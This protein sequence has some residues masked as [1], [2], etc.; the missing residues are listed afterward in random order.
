M[1]VYVTEFVIKLIV[2]CFENNIK[3][4]LNVAKRVSVN[5]IRQRGIEIHDI[6]M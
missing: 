2:I 5:G 1:P 6:H 4:L 3:S